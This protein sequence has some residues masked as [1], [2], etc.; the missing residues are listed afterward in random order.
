MTL[1]PVEILDRAFRGGR[2]T[3]MV[4]YSDTERAFTAAG[5]CW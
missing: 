3:R 1:D 4:M 2:A 5:L